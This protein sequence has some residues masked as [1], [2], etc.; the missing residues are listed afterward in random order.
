MNNLYPAKANYKGKTKGWFTCPH[1]NHIVEYHENIMERV[2]E[3]PEVKPKNEIETRF[4]HIVYV[5][6]DLV[7]EYAKRARAAHDKAEAAYRRAWAARG[8]ARAAYD[9]TCDAYYKA[10]AAYDKTCDAYYKARAAHDKAE[11]AYRRAW[12]IYRKARDAHDKA[13][14]AYRKALK[15]AN[16]NPTL[17]KYLKEHV[18]DCK[19]DGKEIVFPTDDE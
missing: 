7:P 11:A 18:E 1:H 5:P 15:K 19:W 10:R 16:K 3:I 13:E 6:D 4:N 14:V 9:K 2:I 8:K 12:A 17:N